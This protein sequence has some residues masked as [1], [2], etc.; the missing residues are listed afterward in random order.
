MILRM[1]KPKENVEV[2]D[3]TTIMVLT[4]D[5]ARRMDVEEYLVGVLLGELPG[6]F[7]DETLKA[8][9]VAA[10]TFALYNKEKGWRHP[11]GDVCMSASCC[12]A[13]ISPESYILNGGELATVLRMYEA[14]SATEGQ[15]LLY[16]NSLIEAT[17]FSSSGGRTEDAQAVWGVF[18]PYLQ[19]VESEEE[20]VSHTTQIS[21]VDFCQALGLP[22]GEVYIE[23]SSYTNGGGV[24]SV[25]INGEWF[26]GMQ[27]RQKLGLRSTQI[28]F[29]IEKESV[30]IVT[31]GYGHRV[32]MSQYGADAM[33]A[34]GS[35]Y[36]EILQ[37]YYR[38]VTIGDW[39]SDNN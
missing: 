31:R 27:L 18:V 23:T 34:G 3:A 10:R 8:Q 4:G 22:V 38:G 15:V 11:N 13:Y 25:C 5:D 32:G 21:K 33:A 6:N 35:N 39:P 14:A 24:D 26:S 29:Y 37:H 9:A 16:E 36:K 1:A 17:Y 19:S 28:S 20:N 30:R 12:Q 2:V 7:E